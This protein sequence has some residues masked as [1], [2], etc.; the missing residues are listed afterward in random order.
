MI[1]RA[2]AAPYRTANVYSTERGAAHNARLKKDIYGETERTM[3]KIAAIRTVSPP[4]L[5]K[6][7]SKLERIASG[8]NYFA[9][10][11]PTKTSLALQTRGPVPV[12][13]RVNDSEVFLGSLYP[14]GAGRHKL[15]VR[16]MICKSVGITAG[17][18]VRVQIQVR[19]RYA[20]IS[21]P[22]DLA[23]VLRARD[24]TNA[25]KSLPIG[26]KAYLLRLVNEAVKPETRG[27]RIQDAV[28]AAAL[29][30]ISTSPP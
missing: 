16:N 15:R 13:A 19:D 11:V 17:D 28:K 9:L 22:K 8:M 18:T 20:E 29:R 7:R 21:I 25:F 30:Q 3:S 27:K 12:S 2:L 14:I 6:F 4:Q 23:S 26:R 10:L 24:L 1:V 5:L